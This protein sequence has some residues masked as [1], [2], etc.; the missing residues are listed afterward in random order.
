MSSQ[1]LRGLGDDAATRSEA[2][3]RCPA[4][5][6]G[7]PASGGVLDEPVWRAEGDHR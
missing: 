2:P 3:L 7:R 5:Q 4:S 6:R 1:F